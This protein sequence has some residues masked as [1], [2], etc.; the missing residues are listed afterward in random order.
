MSTDHK[1]AAIL[2]ADIAGYTAMMQKNEEGAMELLNRFKEELEEI[3]PRHQGRIIQYFGDGCLLAFESSTQSV[4][5]AIALQKAFSKIPVIPVRIGLHLGE[6]VF[7]NNN[8]FGDGVNIASRIESLGIPGAILMSKTIRDQIVNKSEF[9]LIS[10]GFFDFKNVTEPVEVYAVANPGFVVPKREEMQ[11]KLKI[12]QKKSG[13]VKWISAFALIALLAF[14]LWLFFGQKKTAEMIDEKSIAVLPFTDLSEGKDQEYFSDGLS[15]ELLNLLAKIPELKVIGRTS[16]FSFKGKNEDLRSIGQKLGVAHLLGGSVRKDGNKIRVTAQLIKADDGSHLWNESYNRDLKGI[17]KLQDEIAQAVVQQ[18]KVKLLDFSSGRVS[19]TRNIEAYNRILQGNY[20]FDKLDKENVAK[21]VDFY[22][23]ALA[24]DST[25]ALAWGK[26]ANA[27]SR[28]S[29]QNYIEQ[30]TGYETARQAALKA[31]SLNNT[32]AI[33]YL[34]LADVKL[35]HDFDWKGAQ[36]NY[37]MA[38]KL[39]PGNGEIINGLGDVHQS[40]GQL[41]KAEEFYRKSIQLNP[42]KPITYMNLGNT[43]T[44]AGRFEEAIPY[45]KTVLEL[46]PQH[47]R[48]HMYI[49]RNYI[50]M[51]KPQKALAEMEKENVEVFRLFGLA[52][53]YHSLGRKQEADEK[54]H[55]FINTYQHDWSYLIV[56]LYAFTGEKDKAITWLESAYNKRDSW[57]FWIKGDQL[58]KNIREDARY[59]AILKKMNL[60]L[61]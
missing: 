9:Q 40:V 24:I 17:F 28:Q 30:N 13:A 39:E 37:E 54:L 33:G 31:I 18:L 43:L 14:A 20:F 3:T 42:L 57:L 49:G 26:L 56:Q 34:E 7:K 58:L 32:N 35:Y 23:Q 15:E 53:A 60:A 19:G 22:N 16:S 47:Q 27:V 48:A 61:D 38:L 5:C 51:G 44:T 12:I 50:L 41:K 8:V 6:V 4:H 2:F 46:N 25:D 59:I 29:W 45:F 1:L 36:S 52:L 55:E 11:G 21:A 10:M